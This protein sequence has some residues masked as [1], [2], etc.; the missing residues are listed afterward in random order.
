MPDMP[1]FRLTLGLD[2]EDTNT[3][4]AECGHHIAAA[5][6]RDEFQHF[7][8]AIDGKNQFRVARG[9]HNTLHLLETVDLEPVDR[10]DQI[11][12]LKPGRL[13]GAIC[14]NTIDCRARGWRD[15]SHKKCR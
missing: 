5:R 4:G 2:A 6:G 8:T 9:L 3:R 11:A 12:W 7:A 1:I 10:Y 14:S 13:G 15:R